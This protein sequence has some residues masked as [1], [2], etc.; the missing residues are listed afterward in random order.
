MFVQSV[1]FPTSQAISIFLQI[2]LDGS[3]CHI[4]PPYFT[5][6]KWK[7]DGSSAHK[8]ERTLQ[9]FTFF[10]AIY[11]TYTGSARKKSSRIFSC[12]RVWITTSSFSPGKYVHIYNRVARRK[13]IWWLCWFVAARI[14][15]GHILPRA[16][17]NLAQ[18][19][20]DGATWLWCN[21]RSQLARL[22][23]YRQIA[24]RQPHIIL[25]WKNVWMYTNLLCKNVMLLVNIHMKNVNDVDF[26]TNI[27]RDMCM[28]V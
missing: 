4:F 14:D 7:I 10:P 2:W 18:I 5:Q 23:L 20:T 15:H 11:S 17:A 22:I 12:A 28:K 13:R 19:G 26:D 6:M 1:Q 8:R 24:N 27:N 25:Q 9:F 16:D 3:N 21:L